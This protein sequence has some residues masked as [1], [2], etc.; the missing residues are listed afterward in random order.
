MKSVSFTHKPWNH[1]EPIKHYNGYI[2]C[3]SFYKHASLSSTTLRKYFKD[4]ITK[5]ED[6][7]K[8]TTFVPIEELCQIIIEK[9]LFDKEHIDVAV[10]DLRGLVPKEEDD[11]GWSC[12]W[13]WLW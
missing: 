9:G 7:F 4:C 3:A 12:P 6:K 1:E 10:G 11:K 5:F 13:R 8:R 2:Q